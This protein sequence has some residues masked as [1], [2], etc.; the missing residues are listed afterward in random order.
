LKEQSWEPHVKKRPFQRGN[1]LPVSNMKRR[2]NTNSIQKKDLKPPQGRWGES[3]RGISSEVIVRNPEDKRPEC[4]NS[5]STGF[6]V[7]KEI[8]NKDGREDANRS[9]RGGKNMAFHL[10][11]IWFSVRILRFEIPGKKKSLN[12]LSVRIFSQGIGGGLRNASAAI[13]YG[14]GWGRGDRAQ[15]N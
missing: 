1:G 11:T 10:A 2:S 7:K 15:I 3:C 12:K 4:E 13:C 6:K 14:N 9:F 8:E 5:C